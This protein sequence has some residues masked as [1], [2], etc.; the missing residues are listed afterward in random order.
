MLQLEHFMAEAAHHH[1]VLQP[2]VAEDEVLVLQPAGVLPLLGQLLDTNYD[3][4]MNSEI[5]GLK[6]PD[7]KLARNGR[8]DDCPILQSEL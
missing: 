3:Y 5:S 1:L 7:M 8:S 6:F 2:G 4:V